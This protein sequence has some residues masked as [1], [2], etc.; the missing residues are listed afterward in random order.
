VGGSDVR[1]SATTGHATSTNPAASAGGGAAAAKGLTGRAAT[2][3]PPDAGLRIPGQGGDTP[4]GSGFV[5]FTPSPNYANDHEVYGSGVATEGCLTGQCPT[6]FHSTDGGVTWTRVWSIAF[7][8]GTVLLPPAYPADSRIFEIDDHALRISADSGHLFRP[9][10]PLG[11]HAAMSPGFSS[12]DRQI[13]VGAMP[14]WIY[15]DDNTLVTPF[16]LA[17]EPASIALSFAYS[18]SYVSDRKLIV[19]GTALGPLS[20][21]LVSRC[22]GA[23]CT[24]ATPLAGSTGTPSLLAS[25]TYANS[26]LAYAW[27]QSR[28]YRSVDGGASFAA[29]QLPVTGSVQSVAEDQTGALYV[30]LLDMRPG[31]GSSGG[32]FVSHDTGS[33]WSRVGAGTAL[34]RGATAVMPL[35][36][37]RLLVA[38]YAA[39]GG[40]LLCSG[41]NGG[42]FAPRCSMTSG[43]GLMPGRVRTSALR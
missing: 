29:L 28:F 20:Q 11:G 9:L 42:T 16:N 24:M 1:I 40:G 17:P 13:L 7:G 30:A 27:Q 15:H 43:V 25:R 38:P 22:V 34:D 41:D 6:L 33:T 21:S 8:G 3:T 39:N 2:P 4:E 31:N 37:G 12:V 23:T 14:G 32:V 10:T 19:A 35:P 26:A 5:S 36:D 18:P